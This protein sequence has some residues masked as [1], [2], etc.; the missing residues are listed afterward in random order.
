[1]G[2]AYGSNNATKIPAH[3]VRREGNAYPAGW[4][5]VI[6]RKAPGAMSAMALTVTPV[7]PRVGNIFFCSSAILSSSEFAGVGGWVLRL[8]RSRYGR[9]ILDNGKKSAME[10]RPIDV[11]KGNVNAQR[12]GIR[13]SRRHH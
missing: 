11:E 10:I 8:R 1:M 12:T 9:E 6:H 3:I 2:V 7:K 13:L 4:T 5:K